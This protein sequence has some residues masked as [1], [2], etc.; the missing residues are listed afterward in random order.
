MDQDFGNEPTDD[1]EMQTSIN[2]LD[3]EQVESP[4]ITELRKQ[5]KAAEDAYKV[6]K[7]DVDHPTW[8]RWVKYMF[9]TAS[10]KA[11]SAETATFIGARAGLVYTLGNAAFAIGYLVPAILYSKVQSLDTASS[12]TTDT[13]KLADEANVAYY[14]ANATG[15]GW[16]ALTGIT[17][18]LTSIAL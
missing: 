5:L 17:V 1:I 2:I 9:V 11:S 3:D 7:Q 4:Q 13:T 10:G 6:A 8:G 15:Y 18:S 16:Q 12:N 14:W